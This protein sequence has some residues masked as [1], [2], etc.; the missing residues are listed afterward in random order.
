MA[1]RP[2][3]SVIVPVFGGATVLPAL[4]GEVRRALAYTSWEL[5]FVHDF[6]PGDA[7]SVIAALAKED[8]RIRG[9]DLRQNVGQHNAVMAGLNYAQAEIVVMM[10]DDLQHAPSDIPKLVDAIE[11]GADV[12]YAKFRTRRHAAWKRFGSWANDRLATILLD[13]PKGLYLSPFK[14]MRRAVRDEVIKYSGPSVYVDGLIL[15]VTGN[16][17]S[18]EVDHHGRREGESAY[19]FAKSVSLLLRMSTITSVA[20]LRLATLTGSALA[21]LGGVLAFAFVLQTLIWGD[22][23]AGWPSLAVTVLILGGV[24]LM[25]L[26]VIGEYVGRIFLEVRK[27]PQFV[28]KNTIGFDA[29]ARPSEAENLR[30]RR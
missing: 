4:A 12:C 10:D 24:Q 13:K 30:A 3:V 22:L 8:D 21:L 23:P 5:V 15:A 11:A 25:A 16:I 9:V 17:V 26:G 1:E 6:G 2:N 7:W 28:V 20:P 29:Q 14:A 19:T 27:R 18:I